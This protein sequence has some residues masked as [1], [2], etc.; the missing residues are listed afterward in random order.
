MT[1]TRHPEQKFIFRD[2]AYYFC[3][4]NCKEQFQNDPE[5]YI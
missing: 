3:S 5:K 4:L 2:K 1:I